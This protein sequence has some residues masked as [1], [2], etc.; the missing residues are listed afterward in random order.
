MVSSDHVSFPAYLGV[1]VGGT[2]IKIGIV[3][4]SGRSLAH[5][6]IDT[7][8]E[9]GPEDGVRR[10]IDFAEGLFAEAGLNWEQIRAVGL[11][12]PGTMDVKQ[13][14][15]LHMPNMSG[16]DDFPI[17][18]Y[19]AEQTGK[20]VAFL[21]DANAAAYGEYW[22]GRGQEYDSLIMF[23]LGTG[24]G[25][26]VIIHDTT[27]D[28]EHSHGS[29][30]GHIIIDSSADARQCPCGQF[31]HLEAYVSA[32]SVA[33][34]TQEMLADGAESSLQAIQSEHGEVS[35][36]DVAKHAEQGDAFANQMIRETG[37]Y[38]ATGIT[39]ALH[40]IDPD[41]VVLGGAMNFGGHQT[42]AG[43]AFLEAIRQRIR[44]LTFPVLEENTIIDFATLG[45]DSGYIGAAG[46]ARKQ[47][48]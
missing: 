29:E 21:N 36:L 3:D 11:G 18:S 15:L 12:T 38:L 45:S 7:D 32:T 26:G 33:K 20:P 48:G 43:R 8:H 10:I 34:R 41:I 35:S 6:K 16:W 2:T 30:C 31:G 13:G 37:H 25:G 4:D 28:G 9:R 42:R 14:M 46:V 1:D 24:V 17:R 23:T 44:E 40:I 22:V 47:F 5:G 39:S 19:L 27:L